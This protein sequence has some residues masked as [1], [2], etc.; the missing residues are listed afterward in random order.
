PTTTA[1]VCAY[2]QISLKLPRSQ[3]RADILL[4]RITR[5]LCI[6]TM[7]SL[8]PSHFQFDPDHVSCIGGRTVVTCR[9]CAGNAPR[10]AVCTS[11]GGQGFNI[12]ICGHCNPSTVRTA[13]SL[14][15][16][17]NT[18]PGSSVSSSPGSSS[19]SSSTSYASHSEPRRDGTWRRPGD[20]RDGTNYGRVGTQTPRNL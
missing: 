20:A 8:K 6:Y 12:F 17:A 4:S 11:C 2:R 15:T 14:S 3:P 13:S 1:C 19:R 10:G 16:T 18:T 5:P 9:D 7:T